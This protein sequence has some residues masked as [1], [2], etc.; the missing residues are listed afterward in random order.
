MADGG[1]VEAAPAELGAVERNAARH[2]LGHGTAVLHAARVRRTGN[3]DEGKVFRSGHGWLQGVIRST[4]KGG[5]AVA[6][7][8]IVL[9]VQ[10]KINL[11]II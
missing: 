7:A 8:R 1:R 5:N 4:R 2:A 3:I 11:K 6:M 10:E 9:Q